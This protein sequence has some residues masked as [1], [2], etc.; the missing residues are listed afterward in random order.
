MPDNSIII[1]TILTTGT[2]HFASVKQDCT[3]Q[4]VIDSLVALDEV[5]SDILGDLEEAG[6][7]L[8]KVRREEN[9]RTWEEDELEAIGEGEIAPS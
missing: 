2:L 1:P 7:A 4:D 9:G 8:Q 3:A 5:N 6:W